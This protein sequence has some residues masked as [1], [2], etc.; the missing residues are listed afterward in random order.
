[1]LRV[2]LEQTVR[3]LGRAPDIVYLHN[4][5]ATLNGCADAETVWSRACHTLSDA[6]AAGLCKAWGV[7]TWN[8]LPL[9]RVADAT[10]LPE[11]L[12]VRAGLLVGSRTLTAVEAL[13]AR[14]R[15]PRQRVRG[16][17]PFGGNPADPIWST[18]DPRLF[19]EDNTAHLSAQQAAFRVAYELPKV[20][21]VAV[22]A[23]DPRHLAEL[24]EAVPH[25]V[26]DRVIRAYRALLD[27]HQAQTAVR[28]AMSR[29]ASARAGAPRGSCG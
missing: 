12:M 15:L 4:P 26:D 23:E 10:L 5:E 1:M 8:P 24:L 28:P 14:W 7:A 3:D 22:G 9:L 11:A 21:A 2:T 17:S 20:G 13:A 29:D 18:V 6:A 16:M 25:Q 27:G 19:L